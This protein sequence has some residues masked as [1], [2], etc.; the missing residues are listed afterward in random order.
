ML[1]ATLYLRRTS[2]IVRAVVD[3]LVLIAY[4]GSAAFRTSVYE[5]YGF[6]IIRSFFYCH[7]DNL[8]DNLAALS[9]YT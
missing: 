2:R 8:R 4:K 6:G 3:S 5:S 7:S 9:T 1:Y